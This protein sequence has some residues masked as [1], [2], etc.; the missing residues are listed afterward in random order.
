MIIDL[1]KENMNIS[2]A[3]FIAQPYDTILLEN[4]TY[5][6]VVI[7]DKPHLTFKGKEKTKISFDLWAGKVDIKTGKKLGTTGSAVVKVLETANNT[8]FDSITFE[9]SHVKQ[10]VD[11]GEQ[12]VAFK[13]S[14]SFT[15]IKNCKFI[16]FQDTLYIDNGYMNLVMDSYIEGDIDFI[17]GSADCLFLN[18]E[19]AAKT[20]KELSYYTAP[21]TLAQNRYGFVF[22]NSKF[23]QLNETKSYIGR[24]WYPSGSPSPIIPK[25]KIVDCQLNGNI[26]LNY[27]KMRETNPNYHRLSFYNSKLNDKQ[28]N[29]TDNLDYHEYKEEVLKYFGIN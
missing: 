21:S 18:V 19:A 3:L 24:P 10:F 11:N 28:I 9:N 13:T 23:Y 1:E 22:M 15:L 25:L 7:I 2:E 6:E 20:T 4:K 17:F 5:E 29:N 26:D 14:A 27:L 8:T 12:A 16:S